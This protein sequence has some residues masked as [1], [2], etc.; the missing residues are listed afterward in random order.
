MEET[1]IFKICL[2]Y[3]NAVASELYRD[4]PC[5][6]PAPLFVNKQVTLELPP[7][8]LLYIPV[9]SKV[10]K[11]VLTVSVWWITKMTNRRSTSSD[12]ASSIFVT[13]LCFYV[14]CEMYMFISFININTVADDNHIYVCL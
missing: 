4:N 6:V 8:R 9:L 5:A 3:W 14:V 1:E 2:E 12:L 13:S 11:C 7:R 10:I